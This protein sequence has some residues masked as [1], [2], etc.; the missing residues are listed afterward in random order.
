MTI[1]ELDIL[2]PVFDTSL[3]ENYIKYTLFKMNSFVDTSSQM[4]VT[5]VISS[6]NS[7]ASIN[8]K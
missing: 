4:I 6:R 8:T 2:Q 5:G 7:M 3:R 1:S